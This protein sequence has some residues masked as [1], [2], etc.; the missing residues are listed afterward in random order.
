MLREEEGDGVIAPG[1]ATRRTS[2]GRLVML[3]GDNPNDAAATAPRT[4]D[5]GP[6]RQRSRSAHDARR[7]DHGLRPG[8]RPDLR[9]AAVG[10]HHRSAGKI[11][12]GAVHDRAPTP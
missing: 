5:L 7:P 3:W 2:P 8:R 10:W 11:R 6:R 12:L 1:S 9:G 4:G